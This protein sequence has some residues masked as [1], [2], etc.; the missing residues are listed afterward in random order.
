MPEQ[1]EM[2]DLP[3]IDKPF[4]PL[5]FKALQTPVWTENK[6]KL[7]ERYLYYFVLITHHGNYIDGFAGPQEPDKPAT[8]AAKLVLESKPQWLRK[9]FLCEQSRKGYDALASLKESQAAVKGRSI[10]LYHGDFNESIGEI[11]NSGSIKEKD[12]SFCLLDQRTFECQW[13]TLESLASFT[14]DKFKIELFYFLGSGWLHRAISQQSDKTVIDAWWGNKDWVALE[15]LPVSQLPDLFCRR[16]REELG[17]RHAVP[18][19]IYE[20]S[21]GGKVMYHMIHATDHEIAPALMDR[22]YRKVV[23]SKETPEQLQIE[24]DEWK[25]EHGEIL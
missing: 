14:K 7:I 1:L 4:K 9:F 18:W 19:P 25:K 24:F 10:G 21:D 5:S 22:S 3:N 16:F 15:K 20:R 13:K 23:Y 12:A 17:Y 11:L 6:A 2:F 8:W